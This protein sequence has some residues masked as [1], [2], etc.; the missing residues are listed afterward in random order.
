MPNGRIGLVEC[1]IAVARARVGRFVPLGLIP[2]P[3]GD[4]EEIDFA[5]IPQPIN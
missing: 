5:P 2:G 3:Q 1:W 4:W